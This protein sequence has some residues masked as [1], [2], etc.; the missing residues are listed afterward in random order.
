[1]WC[2]VLNAVR[3]T[4]L[5]SAQRGGAAAELRDGRGLHAL[6]ACEQRARARVGHAAKGLRLL[7]ADV[8]R[9]M[10]LIS[11]PLLE[12]III[13]ARVSSARDRAH[14]LVEAGSE[15]LRL[16][17]G[18][19]ADAAERPCSPFVRS[20]WVLRARRASCLVLRRNFDSVNAECL[21]NRARAHAQWRPN[22]FKRDAPFLLVAALMGWSC[23]K[24]GTSKST[25]LKPATAV[26][27]RPKAASSSDM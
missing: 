10:A 2:G 26:I 21:W 12:I 3:A 6:R 16:G 1:M 17:K 5:G 7:H 11:P 8:L 18:G 25:N 24:A 19:V 15:L 13:A 23:L 27:L 4:R 9:L 22:L 20:L 14:Q